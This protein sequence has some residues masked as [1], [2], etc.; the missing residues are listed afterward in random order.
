MKKLKVLFHNRVARFIVVGVTNTA[1]SFG[2]LNLAFY[3]L[4]QGKI[5][6]SIIATTCAVTFSFIL[7]RHFV[8][9]DKSRRLHQQAVPFVLVTLIGS[10]LILNTVYIVTIKL[11][12]GHETFL[13]DLAKTI[14]GI[15]FSKNFVDI[16]FATVVGA[17]AALTWN[18][19]GYR[20]FVFKGSK[21]PSEIA[22]HETNN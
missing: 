17:A 14:T 2:V 5:V 19:N 4:H 8:F 3:K 21:L 15:K 10:V 18:Y 11:L 20:L 6:S 1:I 13:I 16:N 12:N 9:S 22:E 7:N